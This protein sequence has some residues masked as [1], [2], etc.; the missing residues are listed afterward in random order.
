VESSD[1]PP[2]RRLFTNSPGP[3]I[4]WTVHWEHLLWKMF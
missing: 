2:E 4:P 1:M 3:E